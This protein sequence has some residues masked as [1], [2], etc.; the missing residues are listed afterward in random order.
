[1]KK[2]PPLRREDIRSKHFHR[3]C[4]QPWVRGS[5]SPQHGITEGDLI[6]PIKPAEGV[7]VISVRFVLHIHDQPD[8][9]PIVIDVTRHLTQPAF[10]YL[11]VRRAQDGLLHEVA[12]LDQFVALGHYLSYHRCAPAIFEKAPSR[13]VA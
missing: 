1:M 10:A 7:R 8:L 2:P 13:L 4:D 12:F 9:V 5:V 11:Q 6:D 3:Q